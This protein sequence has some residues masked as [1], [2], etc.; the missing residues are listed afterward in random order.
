M[1]Y[2]SSSLYAAATV[3]RAPRSMGQITVYA[4]NDPAI[5]HAGEAATSTM[6]VGGMTIHW[7]ALLLLGLAAV[8]VVSISKHKK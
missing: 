1:N 6:T 8:L 5:T 7:Q 3:A 4:G 2:G